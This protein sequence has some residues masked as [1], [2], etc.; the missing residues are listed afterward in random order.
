M[1]KLKQ[2]IALSVLSSSLLLGA[3]PNVV[4]NSSSIERDVQAPRDIPTVQ[5]DIVKI[6]GVQQTSF[7]DDGSNKTILIKGFKIVQ[8]YI[9]IT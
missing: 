9:L 1:I 7:Q 4:P 6:E 2:I 8:Y 3:S 5:K